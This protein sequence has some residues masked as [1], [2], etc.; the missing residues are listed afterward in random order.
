MKREKQIEF[1]R[2]KQTQALLKRA[3]TIASEKDYKVEE[4]IREHTQKAIDSLKE[5]GML[6]SQYAT[7]KA[8]EKDID[9]LFKE[10]N[11]YISKYLSKDFEICNYDDFKVR[12]KYNSRDERL[13]ETKKNSRLFRKIQDE[14]NIAIAEDNSEKLTKSIQRLEKEILGDLKWYAV[15]VTKIWMKEEFIKT[16]SFV[17]IACVI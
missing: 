16:N 2:I 1:Q 5:Y 17:K 8:L 4:K 15:F 14:I 10:V 12:H 13:D 3:S 7:K 6:K 9:V 11:Q